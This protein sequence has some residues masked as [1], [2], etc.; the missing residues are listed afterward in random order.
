MDWQPRRPQR[1][2]TIQG[3]MSKSTELDL[4]AIQK[5]AIQQNLIK[6]F[7]AVG[8]FLGVVGMVLH[9]FQPQGGPQFVIGWGVLALFNVLALATLKKRTELAGKLMMC[10]VLVPALS[11]HIY[12]YGAG[13]GVYFAIPTLVACAWALLSKRFAFWF[14]IIITAVFLAVL[15]AS[16]VY[17]YGHF[18][19]YYRQLEPNFY[20]NMSMLM[21]LSVAMV[22]SAVHAIKRTYVATQDALIDEKNQAQG[23][24]REI[25]QSYEDK[26]SALKERSAVLKEKSSVLNMLLHMQELGKIYGMVYI[27]ADDALYHL[28]E[29]SSEYLVATLQET[30]LRY[31]QEIGVDSRVIELIQQALKDKEN[32]DVEFSGEDRNGEACCYRVRGE[33]ELSGERISKII[34]V[35]NDVTEN[36]TLTEKLSRKANTD[37]L[38][39]ILTRRRF[40]EL[41]ESCFVEA[42]GGEK[43]SMYLF[44]DLDRFKIVNDTSGHPAGDA[45]LK[46]VCAMKAAFEA[47]PHRTVLVE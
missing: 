7:A 36:K 21:L 14:S 26:L 47:S 5:G 43:K 20:L 39:G 28:R 23:L 8:I 25:A 17:G 44:I 37:D 13:S 11:L 24:R 42:V 18:Q 32:W 38:T 33:V 19:F 10:A 41:F 1:N 46:E 45:L 29:D 22:S 12:Q 40:E 9:H 30:N 31:R 2:E 3:T 27:P 15:A 6:M 35:V 16:Q 4:A 34:V